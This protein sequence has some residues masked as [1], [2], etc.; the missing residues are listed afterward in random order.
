MSPLLFAVYLDDIPITRSLTPR[1][2]IILY[3]D[4]ILLI[5]PSIGELQRL[6]INCERQLEWLD[7]HINVKKSHCLRIGPGFN[8]GYARI[9]TSDGHSI[10]WTD[11]I[12]YLGIL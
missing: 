6:L 5:A 3:A 12:R 11:K 10:P 4:D 8:V 1:S 9:T 7:M 2:F